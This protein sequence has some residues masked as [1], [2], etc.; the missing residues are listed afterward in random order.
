VREFHHCQLDTILKDRG[1]FSEPIIAG[2]L[3]DVLHGL[4]ALHEAKFLHRDVKASEIIISAKGVAKLSRYPKIMG[5]HQ[6]ISHTI[7]L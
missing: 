2:V 7:G 6:Q 3:K 5:I 4:K 1:G